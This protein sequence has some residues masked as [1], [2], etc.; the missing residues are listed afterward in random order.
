MN[1]KPILAILVL[2]SLLSVPVFAGREVST[3]LSEPLVTRDVFIDIPLDSDQRSQ[4]EAV[5]GILDESLSGAKAGDMVSAETIEKIKNKV[6]GLEKIQN[7]KHWKRF[8]AFCNHNSTK[9]VAEFVLATGLVVFTGLQFPETAAVGFALHLFG[10]F[11]NKHLSAIPFV[12]R[13]A[14]SS[15]AGYFGF[16]ALDY[17]IY[18]ST[19]FDPFLSAAMFLSGFIASE[20]AV[21]AQPATEGFMNKIKSKIRASLTRRGWKSEQTP[22]VTEFNLREVVIEQM[23]RIDELE[24]KLSANSNTQMCDFESQVSSD[25]FELQEI[26]VEPSDAPTTPVKPTTQA[27]ETPDRK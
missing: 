18:E 25:D 16:R 22:N 19:S 8:I 4:L 1:K 11:V 23:K 7:S 13:V 24:T 9:T 5:K 15:V 27:G 14:I 17:V 3:S 26:V 20:N 12:F 21:G 2:S 10:R 6:S